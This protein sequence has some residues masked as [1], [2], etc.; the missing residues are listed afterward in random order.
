[1]NFV[2][3]NCDTYPLYLYIACLSVYLYPINPE[4][5][6]P[7]GPKFFVGSRVTPKKINEL[8]ISD[9]KKLGLKVFYF[10]KKF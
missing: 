10:C 2:F 6:E 5:A 4:T 1:L 8:K 3:S 7:I 9:L